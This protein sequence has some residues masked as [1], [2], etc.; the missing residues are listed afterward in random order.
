MKKKNHK[1]PPAGRKDPHTY[2]L[3]FFGG[4]PGSSCFRVLAVM[5]SATGSYRLLRPCCPGHRMSE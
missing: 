5:G 1:Q 3:A 4:A 2:N